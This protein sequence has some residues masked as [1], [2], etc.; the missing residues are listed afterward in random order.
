MII[1][2][3]ILKQKLQ[4][5]KWKLLINQELIKIIQIRLYHLIL[6]NYSA[7]PKYS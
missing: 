3:F 2:T 1:I 7:E 4:Q 6:Q 5:I